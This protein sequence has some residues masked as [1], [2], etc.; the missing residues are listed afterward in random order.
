MILNGSNLE[1]EG[2]GVK[3]AEESEPDTRQQEQ[4]S[5]VSLGYHLDTEKCLV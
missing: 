4:L 1:L 2:S 5:P 3:A